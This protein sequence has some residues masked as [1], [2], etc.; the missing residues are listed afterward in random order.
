[1]DVGTAAITQDQIEMNTEMNTDMENNS[2]RRFLRQSGLLMGGLPLTMPA[3]KAWAASGFSAPLGLQHNT[4]I[5]V[6]ADKRVSLTYGD[7]RMVLDDGLQPSMLCT[8]KGTLVVQAQNSHR[9][10]GQQKRMTYPFEMST[11]VSRDGGDTWTLAA[12]PD[13]NKVNIEGAIH[14]LKDGTILALDTY[15]VPGDKPD[16]GVGMLYTSN[17]EYKTLQGPIDVH[18][19]IPNADFYGSTDDGGRPYV[20]QRM[21]RRIVELPNGDLLT[22]MYGLQKGDNTPSG[23][24]PTMKKTRVMLFRSKDK[25]RNWDYVST[26]AVDPSVGTEGFGEPVLGRVAQGRH[27]GR[28]ICL[29]RTGNEMYEAVSDDE[30]RTWSKPHPRVFADRDVHK[31]SEWAEMFKDVKRNGVLISQNPVEFTGAVVDPDLITLRNGVLVAS[32][33]IRIPARAAFTHPE[34]PWNGNYLAFSLDHGDTWSHVVQL[35]SGVLTTHYTALEEMP[36]ENEFFVVYDFG[37]WSSKVGR[38]TYGRKVKLNL[39]HG[40]SK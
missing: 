5:T 27:A 13:A 25:G 26:V 17:D 1:M 28:L 11:V 35:T 20:A 37:H 22:N 39:P 23:Y 36:G 38:Y 32:F 18:F 6:L 19:R 10:T 31:T 7:E 40:L 8:R 4:P 24:T 15:V 2:R 33:G 14:Q 21:H 29:M 9:T 12:P 3:I 30:G 16:T 34:H